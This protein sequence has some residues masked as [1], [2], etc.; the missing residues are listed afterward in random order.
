MVS[1]EFQTPFGLLTSSADI[2][3]RYWDRLTA[4]ERTTQNHRIRDGVRQI[5]A[6]ITSILAY[7]YSDP[8]VGDPA[9]ERVDV[10]TLCRTIATDAAAVWSRGHSFLLTIAEEYGDMLLDVVLFRRIVQNLLSNAFNYTEPVG[11]VRLALTRHGNSVT[12]EAADSGI[13]IDGDDQQHIF[14]EYFRGRNTGARRGLGLGLAIVLDA[15]TQLKGTIR[16]ESAPG[17][18][19]T[20]RVELP[21]ET[22]QRRT[23]SS[24]SKMIRPYRDNMELILRL[25]SYRA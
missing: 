12:L 5:N 3:D 8:E 11:S 7:N 15:V 9:P 14:D 18:G 25:E 13:G 10:G 2:L 6:L 16:A 24:S 20:M 23:P 1:H 17:K 19:T 22:W 4:E 21:V